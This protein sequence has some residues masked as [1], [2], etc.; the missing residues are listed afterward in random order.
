[1]P[2]SDE[3]FTVRTPADAW[4]LL[5]SHLRPLSRVE[6]VSTAHALGRVLA[7]DVVSPEDLPAFRRS[8]VD[9]YAVIAYDTYGATAGLPAL[10]SVVGEAPMG[11]RVDTPITLGQAVG[12]HTGSMIPPDAD[13]VV[14]VEYTQPAG[15]QTRA[16]GLPDAV[17]VMRPVAEGENVLQVGEDARVG[18]VVARRGH[19]LRPADI[20]ALM[21]L[22]ITRVG[23][24]ARPRVGILS[25]GDEVIPP[26]RVPE[27]GQ[28][29]D[30]NAYAL[31]A[32][33]EQAGGEPLRYG[34]ISDVRA[35]LERAA[36]QARHECDAVVLSA[37]SSVSYRDM[38]L[39]VIQGLGGPGVLVHGVSV[40]PGKP[41]ILAMADGVPVFGLPGNPASAMVVAELFVVPA[42]RALLGASAQPRASVLARLARNVA[43]TTGREDFVPVRLETRPDG[44]W[45]VPVFGK[46]NLIVTLLRADGTLRVA[47][48]E[49]GLQAG[50]WVTVTL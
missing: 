39:E 19:C 40:K 41:T 1:M 44:L 46:S 42:I 36:G 33:I 22:G 28:V 8:T 13:A 43:S 38:S 31:S 12:V 27:I 29:R 32:L 20:G 34:I 6:V 49:N 3:L 10:L 4:A 18:G 7:D 9:G 48:D 2:A 25:T 21:A 37:G 26:D 5:A 14:M 47:Q 35:D 23:V 30:V 16:S 50:A 15:A 17:E 24:T 45:A 11:E